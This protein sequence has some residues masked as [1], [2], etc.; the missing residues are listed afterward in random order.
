M[1]QSI[2]SARGSLNSWSPPR[3]NSW[4]RARTSSTTTVRSDRISRS[5]RSSHSTM[6]ASIRRSGSSK[7]TKPPKAPRRCCVRSPPRRPGPRNALSLA[8]MRRSNR[9]STGLMLRRRCRVLPDLRSVAVSGR[10][11][12]RICSPGTSS[13]TERSTSSPI[14]TAGSSRNT[15]VP[16]DRARAVA[17]PPNHLP[18]RTLD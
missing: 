17:N 14:A 7:G 9:S 1:G 3:E 16:P 4:R 11:R 6:A 8:G 18:G 10:T 15:A 13:A 2:R 5:R 12:S